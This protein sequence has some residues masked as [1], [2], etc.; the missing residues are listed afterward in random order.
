[1][2]DPRN[3]A[4]KDD[5]WDPLRLRVLEEEIHKIKDFVT[6]SGG[7]AWHFMSP[8]HEE[9]KLLHDHKDID[10]FVQPETYAMFLEYLQELGYERTWTQYDRV[11]THFV[12][13]GK[14]IETD[15]KSV[16][17]LFDIFIKDVPSVLLSDSIRIVKPSE[18][19]TYYG[20]IH[21]TDDCTAVVAAKSLLEKGIDPVGRKELIKR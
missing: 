17:V 1:M 20:E 21:T 9:F 5:K 15:G 8:P 2:G 12:R 14:Y 16:K 13:Y 11:S 18:L 10:C 6:L 3:P 7:W 19:I 4:R